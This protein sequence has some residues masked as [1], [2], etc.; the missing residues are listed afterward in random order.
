MP[1]NAG[2][3]LSSKSEFAQEHEQIRYMYRIRKKRIFQTK[4]PV[5]HCS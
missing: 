2:A 1:A 5:R 3:C 4:K